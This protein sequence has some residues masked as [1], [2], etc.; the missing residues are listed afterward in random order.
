MVHLCDDSNKGQYALT[1]NFYSFFAGSYFDIIICI[2]AEN[3]ANSRQNEKLM[4]FL[5]VFH[6]C[7]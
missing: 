7:A 1:F 2:A 6:M 3:R 4:S 5:H